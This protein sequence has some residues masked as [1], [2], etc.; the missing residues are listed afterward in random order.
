MHEVIHIYVRSM[1]DVLTMTCLSALP[2]TFFAIVPWKS[3]EYVNM[4]YGVCSVLSYAVT[5]EVLGWIW[6][7]PRALA[8]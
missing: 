4:V 6:N 8:A 2:I 1:H 5:R 7:S 3:T